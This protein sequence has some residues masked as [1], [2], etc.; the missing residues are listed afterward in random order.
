VV[1]VLDREIEFILVPLGIA[2]VLAA[3]IGQHAQELDI[4]FF[5]ERQH[6][7]VEQIRRRDR[8]LDPVV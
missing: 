6:P 5:E 4:V 3:T 2:A 1:D 8:C 7:V